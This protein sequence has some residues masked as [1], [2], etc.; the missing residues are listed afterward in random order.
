MASRKLL[1]ERS[2]DMALGDAYD[3]AYGMTADDLAKHF[4]QPMIDILGQMIDGD[5][6][7]D[8]ED[9][10]Y[11]TGNDLA[12]KFGRPY[13]APFDALIEDNFAADWPYLG[14]EKY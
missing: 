11:M 9:I 14:G 10:M 4:G 12:R 7:L 13:M 5:P 1:Q 6:S 3:G 8:M 2:Q